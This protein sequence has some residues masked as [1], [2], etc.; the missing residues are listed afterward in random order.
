MPKLKL[1]FLFCIS[2]IFVQCVT[3]QET[4]PV[5]GV[6]NKN[7]NYYAFINAK[8]YTDYETLIENGT[9]LI[10][11]GA[12]VEVGGKVTLPKGTVVYNLKGKYIYPSLI[13]AYTGYGLPETKKAPRNRTGIPQYETATKGA[14]SWNQAIKAEFDA[15]RDFTY[16][17]KVAEEYRK[18]GF[19]TV[20]TLERDGIARGSAAVVTLAEGRE[21][22]VVILDK[23]AACYSFDKGSST[24]QYPQSLMGAIALLRQTYLD[25]QWYKENQR[26]TEYNA[27]LLAWNNLLALPQVFEVKDR[28]SVLRA[29]NIAKEFNTKYI[30]K[31]AGDEYM[32]LDEIK[33][34]H[35]RFILPLNFPNTYDVEDPYDAVNVSIEE[36]KHWEMA[37]ANPQFFE[38]RGIEFALTASDL[39]D[40]NDFWKNLRKAI[41]YGLTEKQALKALTV[42]PAEM[43]GTSD[44]VGRLKKD[45]L[46]NFIITSGKLFDAKTKINENWIQGNQYIIN[47]YNLPDVRGN[48]DLK[49]GADKQYELKIKGE[50]ASDIKATM[51]VAGDTNKIAAN[52]KVEH[53]TVTVSYIVKPQKESVRLSG[54]VEENNFRGRG[55]LTTGEWI[56]WTAIYKSEMKEVAKKDTTPKP[57]IGEV[58]YP[59][60]AFGEPHNDKSMWQQYKSRQN[61]ILI[62]NVTVWTNDSIGVLKN[63]DV[64]INS[65]RIVAIDDAIRPL[66]T[67]HANV[68][69]G[70]GKH[71]TAGIIDEHSH[72]AISDNVNEG[73]QAVTAEVRIGD[74][75]NSED[76]NIYRQLAGGVTCSQ[77]LHGSAN[78]IG[79]QSAL[80][81]LRWG[82]SPEEMK[83]KD[84]D[85][86]IKFALGENVKQSNWGE[87]NTIRFPQSRMGVE[88]VYYDAFT[89]AKEY[90]ARM[91]KYDGLPKSEKA[92][93]SAPRRDLELDAL[94]EILNKQRSI[95]C[96][97]YVQSEV[98][99]LMHVSDSMG[100]KINTFT[101]ILEGYKVADKMKAHG[102]GGSTFADWWA[103][104]MEVKEAIPYNA[105]I[106]NK[107]GIVT[108]VNSDDAEM[109]RRLN[110]EAAKTIKYGGLSEE[111]ALK[112][113]TLNPAKLLHLDNRVGHVNVGYD[114]DVVLW[115]DNPLS[116][117]AKV[118]KTIIDGIIYYDI[119][120][121][122]KMR[123]ELEKE[124][125]RLIQKMII[126]K[127]SGE[128]TQ[129]AE[130]KQDKMKRCDDFSDDI[131]Q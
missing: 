64:Y 32:R 72:I 46:A 68:I 34:T 54:V 25:G 10:K 30:I 40:K 9:L 13:D 84:A 69:D 37:P 57:S 17:K 125:T 45:M 116:I 23:A 92:K 14:Y 1:L 119:D 42:I 39:K 105:A 115:S 111:E 110:Q 33:E 114:A 53:N 62:K 86:F 77:L 31:G 11:D 93:T 103:Y 120:K 98:N 108:A 67:A 6:F 63:K 36:M 112:L 59:F 79:G 90:S 71:I 52:V 41:E 24:Q 27:S 122:K 51:T 129:K 29:A 3:A 91:K 5:N 74:V 70:T 73:T 126:A 106:M 88:Q 7:H 113:C 78:P 4:F 121:D 97:S 104:K 28:L 58:D 118:E 60:C 82:L 100:F 35:C 16:D 102:I 76:I 117:Y 2:V 18:L 101:H 94:V 61:A 20:L 19:G 107:M 128:K 109:G 87:A 66:K 56:D 99:M 131:D 26:K 96:H 50:S 22:E 85:G 75:V 95:T 80:I 15:V 123:E 89:R 48:Y 127:K 43:T 38:K 130:A 8:I 65:G 49:V 12:I 81:K 55:Q 124:R 83:I 47:D 21:N 44:K